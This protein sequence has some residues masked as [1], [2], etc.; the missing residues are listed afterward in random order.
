M[1]QRLPRSCPA[2]D[3][4]KWSI[5]L[6]CLHSSD[7]KGLIAM[8]SAVM[9]DFLRIPLVLLLS[10]A[11]T[12]LKAANVSIWCS[13]L[14]KCFRIVLLLAFN[15]LRANATSY[16][17]RKQCYVRKAGPTDPLT[18]NFLIESG[19]TTG[20][21]A[22]SESAVQPC[23][24]TMWRSCDFRDTKRPA[25]AWLKMKNPGG[26]LSQTDWNHEPLALTWTDLCK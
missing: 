23:S 15:V 20:W 8:G 18:A 9:R 10:V 4:N 17:P 12:I 2:Q 25:K 26:T 19:C 13:L 5:R 21:K 7:F 24:L 3:N 14:T 16:T 22:R 11:K 6:H 1:H